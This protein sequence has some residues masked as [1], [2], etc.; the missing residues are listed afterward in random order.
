[1][2]CLLIWGYGC[3]P[4]T[5]EITTSQLDSPTTSLMQ[6]ISFVDEEVIWVSGHDATFI[7]SV[8]GGK[9]WDTYQYDQA[10]SLQFR[11]LHAFSDREVV[12]MSA[13]PGALSRIFT[14]SVDNGFEQRYIMPHEE[15]FLNSIAFWDEL[16]GMAF[17]DSFNGKM[18]MLKTIDGGKNWTRI[19]SKSLPAAGDGEGGFA[20]SGACITT[21]PHG[22]A[23]IGTGAG[24]NAR[25]LYSEDFGDTWTY[26]D[27][28]M[29]KGPS[30]GITSIRMVNE[31]L[32]SIVGADL[33]I[34]DDYTPNVAFTF[35]GGRTWQLSNQPQTK[36]GFYGSDLE[37]ISDRMILVACGPAGIDVSTDLGQTFQNISQDNYWAIELL[38]SGVG[39]ATGMDGQ[40]LKLSI[41]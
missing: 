5:V 27:T 36:G 32:G 10:D 9:S 38:P 8:D 1:M 40:L 11:D 7:R 25:V 33:S 23:W 39:L 17:G 15:G 22:Q 24:G 20:A 26:F 16:T 35:D 19:D 31:S 13:G 2:L 6:A 12:L 21:L 30:A 3:S 41:K 28:P 4:S 14:Y 34:T 18:F 29:I 37:E